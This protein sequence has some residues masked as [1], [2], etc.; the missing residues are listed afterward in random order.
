M[1]A[2]TARYQSVGGVA[3]RKTKPITIAREVA[4]SIFLA[5]CRSVK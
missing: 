5:P 3:M 4:V 2:A 1:K